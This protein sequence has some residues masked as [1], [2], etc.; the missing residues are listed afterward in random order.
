MSIRKAEKMFRKQASP[1]EP[2]ELHSSSYTAFPWLQGNCAVLRQLQMW[3]HMLTKPA[4]LKSR[5]SQGPQTTT[6]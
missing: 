6:V 2:N 1:H 5:V 3:P 4:P